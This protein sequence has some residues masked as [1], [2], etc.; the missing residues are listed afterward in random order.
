MLTKVTNTAKQAKAFSVLGVIHTVKPGKSVEV[1]IPETYPTAKIDRLEAAGLVFTDPLDDEAPAAPPPPKKEPSK[2][3]AEKAGGPSQK[4]EA[5]PD[6][7]P[8]KVD[9][10]SPANEGGPAP[11]QRGLE[12]PQ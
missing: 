3:K 2:P 12:P 4:K 11:W 9:G 8:L 6:A 10:G 5:A 1:E 7:P